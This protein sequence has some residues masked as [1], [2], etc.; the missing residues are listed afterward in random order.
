MAR[1]AYV[2]SAKNQE[3]WDKFANFKRAESLAH[4]IELGKIAD[5]EKVEITISQYRTS[6]AKLD[7]VCT[8]WFNLT[9]EIAESVK[10]ENPAIDSLINS[11]LVDCLANDFMTVKQYRPLILTLIPENYRGIAK[12]LIRA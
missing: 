9:G 6:A 2:F 8:D 11:F 7:K 5:E 12:R 3:V 10:A 1:K 4:Q